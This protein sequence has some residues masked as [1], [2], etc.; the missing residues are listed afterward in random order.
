MDISAI[1]G[2]PAPLQSM[3]PRENEAAE[4]RPDNEA[5]E[6]QAA[7]SKAPLPSYAGTKIDVEA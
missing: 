4:L 3:A 2:G 1:G 7:Q 5:G 6:A